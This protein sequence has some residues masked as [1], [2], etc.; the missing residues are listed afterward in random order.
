MFGIVLYNLNLD[1]PT[2]YFQILQIYI[3]LFSRNQ[4]EEADRIP[5]HCANFIYHLLVNV[6]EGH[7]F[8]STDLHRWQPRTPILNPIHLFV[9]VL[10][11]TL[12]IQIPQQ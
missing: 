8:R 12:F 9:W 2:H 5:A 6:F 10:L 11:K 1:R 4:Q 3:H 7:W